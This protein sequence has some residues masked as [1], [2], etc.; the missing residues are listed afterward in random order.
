MNVSIGEA[1]D[2]LAQLLRAVEGG[3]QVTITRHGRPV[4]DLVRAG[5]RKL[6]APQFGTL[7][8]KEVIVDPH[9]HKGPETAEEVQ[10]WLEGRFE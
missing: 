9:W 7:A 5:A 2:K 3:E 8:G 1:R 10:A 4:A 6:K